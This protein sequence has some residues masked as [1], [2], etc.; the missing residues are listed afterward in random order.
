MNDFQS[1]PAVEARQQAVQQESRQ[2]LADYLGRSLQNRRWSPWHD[3][4]VDEM[5]EY[6]SKLSDDTFRLIQGFLGVEEY[7]AD[8]VL[9][10]L[11]AFREQRT[12][13]QLWLQWGAEEM[14]H[15]AAFE[16][17]L[18]HSG[19]RSEQEVQDYL[20]RAGERR[21]D[22]SD[23]AGLD[24]LVGVCIYAMVQER[25]TYLNYEQMRRRIRTEYGLP[26]RATPDEVRRG[27]EIGASEALRKIAADEIAHH[28]IFVKL[29]RIHLRYFPEATLASMRSVLS[30]FEMPGVRLIPNRREFMRAIARTRLHTSQNHQ[31]SVLQ[32][33][34]RSLGLHEDA[35]L[36]S[37]Q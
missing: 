21:W 7:I 4:P 36:A 6:G 18:V 23:H 19:A 5:R 17:V 20:A 27:R 31:A 11:G 1:T 33:I 29:V 28:G 2:A 12:L 14:R 15:G 34:L 37:L 10:G 32:P 26:E 25:A 16:Q 35:A 8:Y 22:P 30:R 9:E 3:L 13:R 24:T